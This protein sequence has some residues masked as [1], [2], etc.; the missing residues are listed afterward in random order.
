M[1]LVL[2][3]LFQSQGTLSELFL[4]LFALGISALLF[5]RQSR[6]GERYLY[7]VGL[8]LGAFIEVG[9]RFLGYQQ[10]WTNASFFGVPFW[11]P[12]AWGIGFVLITRIGIYIRNLEVTD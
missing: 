12:I 3:F 7:L 1:A 6:I 11:L 9:F 4:T 10:V 5:L 8:I 2:F